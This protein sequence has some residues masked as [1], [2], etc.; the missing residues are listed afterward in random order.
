VDKIKAKFDDIPNG[1]VSTTDIL[2]LETFF[3]FEE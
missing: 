3:D 1:L 2:F